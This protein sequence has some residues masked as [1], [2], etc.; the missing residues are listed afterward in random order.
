MKLT[1]IA[2]I[3]NVLASFTTGTSGSFTGCAIN[4]TAIVGMLNGGYWTLTP[5]GNTVGAV[6]DL[7]LYESG[8]S[9]TISNANYIGLIK[10]SNSGNPWSGTYYGSDGTHQNTTQAFY[11][12]PVA[13]ALRTGILSFSDY[14]IGYSNDIV[15]PIELTTFTVTPSNNDAILNWNTSSEYNSDFFAIERSLDGT[16]FN[17]I[18][19]V[20]AAGTSLMPLD[21][22]FIDYGVNEFSVN[23]IYYR[24]RMVDND[25]TFDYSDIR[26]IN[27]ESN[28]HDATMTVF[29]NPF[30]DQVSLMWNSSDNGDAVLQLT[31]V[32][33]KIISQQNF[34]FNKG[35]N[36]ILLNQYSS[37]AQGV[38]FLR[39]VY[40]RTQLT[41][42]LVKQ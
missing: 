41:Q 16:E 34:E 17:Q 35:N 30:T 37:L 1:S 24:L 39:L 23:K 11:S 25:A 28:T 20:T 36:F 8:Y 18:G 12:G 33:G 26:W 3:T 31:D 21:Y 5:T 9:N 32:S 14:A 29:P 15:L 10:R 42:K 40:G 27:S 6:Y 4:G 38:Y 13:K 7:T 22:S 19:T 2:S